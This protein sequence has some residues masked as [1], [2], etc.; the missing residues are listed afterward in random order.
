DLRGRDRRRGGQARQ[1]ALTAGHRARQPRVPPPRRDDPLPGADLRPHRGPRGRRHSRPL[2]VD[3]RTTLGDHRAASYGA[4][5]KLGPQSADR[6]PQRALRWHSALPTADCR[7]RTRENSAYQA[8]FPLA[9]GTHLA[10]VPAAISFGPNG[11][12]L[13][14]TQASGRSSDRP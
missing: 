13:Y 3:L 2:L 9:I 14:E 4:E 10:R 8:A 1:G 5:A 6:S 12:F 11:G 7:L